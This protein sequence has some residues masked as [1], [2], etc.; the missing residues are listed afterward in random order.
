M[1]D[2]EAGQLVA[3]SLVHEGRGHGRVHTAGQGTDDLRVADL[4]ADLLNLLVHDGTGGPR[5]FQAGALVEE[6]LQRVLAEL[7]VAHLGGA[8]AGRRGDAHATRRPRRE[9]RWWRR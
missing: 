2:E 6:V 5:G 8:T 4:L 3:D 7:G 9:S 1:I